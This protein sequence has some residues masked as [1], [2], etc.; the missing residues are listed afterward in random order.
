[1]E[2]PRPSGRARKLLHFLASVA[3]ALVLGKISEVLLQPETI[4][5]LKTAQTEAY[6]AAST[7]QPWHLAGLYVCEF[8]EAAGAGALCGSAT[9][10]ATG[11]QP[12]TSPSPQH[13]GAGVFA[14]IEALLG[15]LD[16]LIEQPST[17]GSVFAILQFLAGLLVMIGIGFGKRERGSGYY[18]LGLPLGTVF[19]GYVAGWCT[20]MLML[21]ELWLFSWFTQLAALCCGSAGLAFFGYEFCIKAAEVK[22]HELAT[23]T[24]T[25]Q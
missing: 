19:F 18:L 25:R 4:D 6:H 23:H 9:E 15:L 10:G 8:E 13:R 5:R 17:F 16:R 1:M 22:A 11:L 2:S 14:P 21:A 7:F 3:I 24:L 12:Y 20:Q